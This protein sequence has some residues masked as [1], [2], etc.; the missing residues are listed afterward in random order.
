[1]EKKEKLTGIKYQNFKEL[2]FNQIIKQNLQII[3]VVKTGNNQNL[4]NIKPF[5]K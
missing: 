3:N 1:M 5:Q 4:L 2:F